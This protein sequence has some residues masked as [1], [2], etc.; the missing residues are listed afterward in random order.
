MANKWFDNPTVRELKEKFREEFEIQYMIH[1]QEVE[2]QR[3]VFEEE[4]RSRPIRRL[5][6]FLRIARFFPVKHK[7]EFMVPDRHFW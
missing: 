2:E 3:E 6:T 1:R 4:V 5:L 7:H